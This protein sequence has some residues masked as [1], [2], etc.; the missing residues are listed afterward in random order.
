MPKIEKADLFECRYYATEFACCQE[1]MLN[2]DQQLQHLKTTE[3]LIQER[4]Q[5]QRNEAAKYKDKMDELVDMLKDQ[6]GVEHQEDVDWTTGEITRQ[7]TA[8]EE[9]PSDPDD[10]ASLID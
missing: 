3:T 10:P 6:Y 1:R 9:A 2:L 5:Q 8:L 4:L 7:E